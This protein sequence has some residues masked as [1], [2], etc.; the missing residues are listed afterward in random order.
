[1]EDI[2]L[3]SLLL[4]EDEICENGYPTRYLRSLRDASN[5]FS[6]IKR[7]CKNFI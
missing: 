1:M 3:L 5:L 4:D 2:L 7:L 6:L